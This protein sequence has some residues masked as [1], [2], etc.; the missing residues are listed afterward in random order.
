[1]SKKIE[2]VLEF[3]GFTYDFD[4]Y[5]GVWVKLYFDSAKDLIAFY[6]KIKEYPFNSHCVNTWFGPYIDMSTFSDVC[7]HLGH[8]VVYDTGGVSLTKV[9][10]YTLTITEEEIPL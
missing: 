4:R 10:A 7:E 8:C 5:D 2:Y 1:M 6:N 9:R 3:K